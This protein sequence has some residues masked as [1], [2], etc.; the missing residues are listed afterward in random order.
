MSIFAYNHDLLSEFIKQNLAGDAG[1]LKLPQNQDF[2][3]FYNELDIRNRNLDLK[4]NFSYFWHLGTPQKCQIRLLLTLSAQQYIALV[5]PRVGII[6]FSSV[7]QCPLSLSLSF[8]R[9]FFKIF[10]LFIFLPPLNLVFQNVI[11]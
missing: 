11:H 9:T 3:H 10:Y 5:H 2:Q 7:G 1:H 6:S 8:F 4:Y